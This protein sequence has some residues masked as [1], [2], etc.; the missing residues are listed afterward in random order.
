MVHMYI[1]RVRVCEVH[2]VRAI[3]DC[4]HPTQM[5]ISTW[6]LTLD[7]IELGT[8]N[9]CVKGV[10]LDDVLIIVGSKQTIIANETEEH[11][12]LSNVCV[13]VCVF[14]YT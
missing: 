6:V 7:N 4:L 1:P 5:S 2:C 3:F 9:L 12:K 14:V 8:V 10:V 11:W 13:C